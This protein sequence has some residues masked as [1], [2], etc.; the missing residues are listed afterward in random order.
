M[1]KVG[2]ILGPIVLLILLFLPVPS[3]LSVAG[4][5]TLAIVS[6]MI[7]WWITEAIPIPVTA[8]IP[9]LLFPL[10]QILPIKQTAMPYAHPIIFL[11]LGGFIL[12]KA[13]QRWHL[14]E[15]IALKVLCHTSS[16]PRLIIFGFMLVVAFLSMWISNTA[17][18]LL[19]LPI[20]LSII[21]LNKSHLDD[22]AHKNFAPVL[23][24]GIAYAASIGGIGTLIGTPPNAFMAAFLQESIGLHI[25]FAKWMMIALP[26]VIVGLPL[27]F[28][29]LTYIAMPVAGK[30]K[31][32]TS[33]RHLFQQALQKLGPIKGGELKVLVIFILTASLWV[34]R[35]LFAKIIPG[36][37]DTG[38][39]MFAALLIF[40]LPVRFKQREPLL[41]WK[42]AVKLPWGVLLLFGG[43][44]SMAQAITSSG[45]GIWLGD[46][47]SLLNHLPLTVIV[48]CVIGGMMLLTELTSN[49]ATTA[50]LLPIITAFATSNQINPLLLVI[51]ATLAASCAFMLP[52]ATPPNA[53]VFSSGE[54]NMRQM[55]KAGV[56]LNLLFFCLIFGFYL[57]FKHLI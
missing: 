13:I 43:G 24:L 50:S 33:S 55:I 7:I 2:L 15:R 3:G 39:A 53:V 35:P 25:S 41:H 44:L 9:L 37:S 23:L 54:V 47:L 6:L 29:V 30:L 34:L 51:P 28:F 16:S 18:T 26:I 42:D 11:F 57:V 56:W 19:M 52:I 1:K 27:S 32:Q 12:A 5:H 22:V 10:F 45:L 8:L 46:Q 40:A 36:I 21:Q 17:T 49:I 14:H 31:N 38:I 48:A 20:A 4:W